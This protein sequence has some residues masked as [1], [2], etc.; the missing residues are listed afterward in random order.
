M[1]AIGLIIVVG[2]L[3]ASDSGSLRAQT[4]PGDVQLLLAYNVHRKQPNLKPFFEPY[5]P[6]ASSWCLVIDGQGRAFAWPDP[7][8]PFDRITHPIG[9][10]RLNALY[11]QVSEAGMNRAYLPHAGAIESLRQIRPDRVTVLP[12]ATEVAGATDAGRFTIGVGGRLTDYEPARDDPL[13]AAVRRSLEIL[14]PVYDETLK[15]GKPERL[16]Y[17]RYIY[18]NDFVGIGRAEPNQGFVVGDGQ[19]KTWSGGVGWSDNRMISADTEKRLLAYLTQAGLFDLK[20]V[21]RAGFSTIA[22]PSDAKGDRVAIVQ[23]R[24]DGREITAVVTPAITEIL[25][26][27]R[28]EMENAPDK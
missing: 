7:N 28:R 11:Q 1:K 25:T 21:T 9:K 2:C 18:W 8:R 5:V 22:S 10:D 6:D 14:Q 15:R 26:G 17:V 12:S 27:F 23:A 20:P 13:L 3:L 19:F 24:I 4:Q 16:N